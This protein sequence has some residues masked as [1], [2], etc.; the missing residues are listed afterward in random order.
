M[1][2]PVKRMPVE[3]DVA[4]RAAAECGNE[5]HGQNADIIESAAARLDDTRKSEREDREDFDNE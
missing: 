2:D 3:R 5:S 4:Q 1:L